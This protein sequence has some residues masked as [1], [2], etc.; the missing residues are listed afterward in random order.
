[1]PVLDVR[2]LKA[3]PKGAEFLR[4]VLSRNPDA[5]DPDASPRVLLPFRPSKVRRA[6]NHVPR[7]D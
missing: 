5:R 2:A 7:S 3:D 4:D 1:M 6:P